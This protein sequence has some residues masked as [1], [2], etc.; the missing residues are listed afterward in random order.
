MLEGNRSSQILSPAVAELS[1]PTFQP[2]QPCIQELTARVES[3]DYDD[4]NALMV[5]ALENNNHLEWMVIIMRDVASYYFQQH[6]FSTPTIFNLVLPE[7]RKT[8][9]F[10]FTQHLKI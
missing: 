10:F 6:P 8:I 1:L 3:K 2:N 4:T 5:F 7:V 9:N